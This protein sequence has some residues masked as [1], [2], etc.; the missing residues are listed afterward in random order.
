[1]GR[2]PKE[3][4]YKLDKKSGQYLISYPE[5][6]GHYVQSREVDLSKALQWARRNKSAI[7]A[8][9]ETRL[10]IKDLAPG[11]FDPDKPWYQDRLKKGRGMTA[12]SLRIRQGHIE[13]YI[14][15]LFGEYDIRTITGYQIDQA[16]LNAVGI[17]KATPGLSKGTRAKLLYSIKLMF[18][19][20]Q[21]EGLIRE[22]PTAGIVKYAKAP[23]NPRSTLP[24]DACEK[25]FPPT[26]AALVK[27][28]GSTL[29]GVTMLSLFD[30]GARPGELRAKTWDGY[31]PE[32]RFMPY[33][34][35][36]E[37]GTV[38]TEKDTKGG[39]IS[40]AYVSI[41]TAQELEIWRLESRFNTAEDYIFTTDGRVPLSIA[42][43]E[44]VFKRAL[45]YLG[46]DATGWTPYWLRHT[47]ISYA[48]EALD[49]SQMLMAVGHTT[50][51][52][53]KNYRHLTDKIVLKRS[54][55]IRDSLDK[56]R[57]KKE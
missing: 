22:N 7:V 33:R 9:P 2:L 12:A 3:I 31:Y 46:Y 30:T 26:H 15:P 11:F 23:E 45:A 20:W 51:G 34:K 53:N 41:R 1:M 43:I 6:G 48:A 14:I 36:I 5:L 55:G 28:W 18:D 40:P 37:S 35:A 50:I 17:Q 49:D 56:I 13:N 10:L 4:K 25:L 16:V 32:E 44:N 24:A 27:V 39:Q 52:M 21:Y 38:D 42:T 57:E 29:Y 8:E 47:F 54:V 19:R